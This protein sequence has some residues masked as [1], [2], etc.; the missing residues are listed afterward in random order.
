MFQENVC[1]VSRSEIKVKKIFNE[2]LFEFVKIPDV[3]FFNL[4]TTRSKNNRVISE[5]LGVSI[6][7]RLILPPN[8]DVF[9]QTSPIQ[10]DTTIMTLFGGILYVMHHNPLL[11]FITH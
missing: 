5:F 9:S 2:S 3:F 11:A 8:K 10:T 4:Q 6:V 1:N 7:L